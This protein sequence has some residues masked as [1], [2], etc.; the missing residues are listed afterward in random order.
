[1]SWSVLKLVDGYMGIII[2]FSLLLYMSE[3]F[4]NKMQKVANGQTNKRK[5]GKDWNWCQI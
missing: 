2:L 5:L 4:H 3:T 1:M